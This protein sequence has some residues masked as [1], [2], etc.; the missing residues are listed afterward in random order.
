[1][2]W[3][4]PDYLPATAGTV[5]RFLLNPHGDGDGMLL[6]D[7]TEIHFPPHLWSAVRQAIR[8]GDAVTVRGARPRG[9]DLV[10]A[11]AIDTAAGERIDDHG[12]PAGHKH[13]E[14]GPKAKHAI[15]PHRTPVEAEGVVRRALHGPK[16][17]VRG[18]LF[19]DGSIV[20]FPPHE[21]A[22]L[23][24]MLVPGA[25]LVVEGEGIDTEFGRVIHAHKVRSSSRH[26][27]L[28]PKEAKKPK[29]EPHHPPHRA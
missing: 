1:M 21:A 17:E 27:T 8:P 6:A 26:R 5:D 4:D 29:H 16:G 18:V 9:A 23:V 28:K 14:H 13:H 12:P 7:G 19:E 2:H 24:D 20:R 22:E 25:G 3:L 11:V 10:A 15:K